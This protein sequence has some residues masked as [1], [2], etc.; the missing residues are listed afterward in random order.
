MHVCR[1]AVRQDWEDLQLK[2]GVIFAFG[3]ARGLAELDSTAPPSIGDASALLA[4]VYG[5]VLSVGS[6][7][8]VFGCAGA[9]VQAAIVSGWLRPC[10]RPSDQA[11]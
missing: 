4:F 9:A 3:F 1:Y 6:S 7:T 10:S 8:V 11:Q 5:V 2:Q